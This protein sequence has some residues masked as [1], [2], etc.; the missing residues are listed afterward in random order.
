MASRLIEF[1]KSRLPK[2]KPLHPMESAIAKYWVKTR[3]AHM[4]PELRTDPAALERAYQELD[5]ELKG[6]VGKG[7]RGFFRM[8]LPGRL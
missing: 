8:T 1:I 3:L 5:L 7:E 2:E 4:F 6:R